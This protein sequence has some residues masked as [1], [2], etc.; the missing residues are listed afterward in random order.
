[1]AEA[2][3]FS[4]FMKVLS[5]CR[6]ASFGFKPTLFQVEEWCQCAWPVQV[7]QVAGPDKVLALGGEWRGGGIG[8]AG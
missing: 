4:I 6:T 8:E 7:I 5:G 3:S 1:M 2:T